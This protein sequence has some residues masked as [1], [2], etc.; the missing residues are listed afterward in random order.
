MARPGHISRMSAGQPAQSKPAEQH[1]SEREQYVLRER[2][3]E[4]ASAQIPDNG[5]GGPLFRLVLCM[6]MAVAFGAGVRI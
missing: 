3:L 2:L 1:L 5:L 4:R 6:S